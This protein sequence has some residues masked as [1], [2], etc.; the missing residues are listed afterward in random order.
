MAARK[1]TAAAIYCR[2]SLDKTGEGLG[3]ARQEV[4]GRRLAAAKGW[5]VAEVYVDGSTSAFNGK[6]RPAYRRML[7]DLEAG[8]RDAVIC[9]DLDRLTRHPA[10]LEEFVALAD[11]LRIALANVS[12]DTDLGSSDGRLKARIMGAV[13]RQESER[14]GE[15]VAREAEQAARRGIPRGS[16]RPFG[17]EDD[18]TTIRPS[19]AELVR[20]AAR[21][22]LAGETVPAVARDFNRR[23]IPSPQAARYGWSAATLMGVLR[24]PRIAGLRTYKGQVVADGQ[25]QP[26]LKRAEWETLAARIR[27]VARP[28]RPSSHLLS[29]IARCGRCGGPL[30]TSWRPGND[31]TR[32]ARYA[33]VAR[34]G[35]P[36][37]GKLTV[38]AAPLDELVR[39]AVIFAVSGPELAKTLAARRRGD[40]GETQAARELT[41]AEARREE[42]AAM[43]GAGEITRR[44]WLKIREVTDQRIADASRLLSRHRGPTANLP[45]SHK[46]LRQ[47]WDTGS[48]EWRRALITAVVATLTVKPVTRPINTFD[49]DRIDITWAA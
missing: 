38:T 48:V 17:W 25:W 7:S 15:R 16:R 19:E 6:V 49:P 32:V 40:A 8:L 41:A 23:G 37:C 18:K 29:G 36:G 1:P 44:E 3:V 9:V 42:A 39:D 31:G 20:E 28:G 10:E 13:A 11:R 46:A 24:N 35:G 14:K 34:P 22:V 43:F 45:K 47:A 27:R 26:I 4:L 21:R 2:I 5:P 30:W 12:G 33:C